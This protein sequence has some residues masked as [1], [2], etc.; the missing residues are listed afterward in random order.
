MVSDEGACRIWWAGGMREAA[1]KESI[2]KTVTTI[3]A[4]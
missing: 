3:A 1:N 2:K 4:G